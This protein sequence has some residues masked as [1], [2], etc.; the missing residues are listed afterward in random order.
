MT[1]SFAVMAGAECC[2]RGETSRPTRSD[3]NTQTSI[4]TSILTSRCV[5]L[6]SRRDWGAT[7]SGPES[8]LSIPRQ[9]KRV[10]LL[11]TVIRKPTQRSDEQNGG[12][13]VRA[14]QGDYQ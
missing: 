6:G 12:E 4:L 8:L 5:T 3:A 11:V 9:S 13:Q 7:T 2:A 14:E 1:A 10:E